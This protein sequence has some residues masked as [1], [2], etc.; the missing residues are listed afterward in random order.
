MDVGED[1]WRLR[2]VFSLR[3]IYEQTSSGDGG[4]G[5]GVTRAAATLKTN[6]CGIEEKKSSVEFNDSVGLFV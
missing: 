2:R 1:H 3:S 6:L 5:G 4:E